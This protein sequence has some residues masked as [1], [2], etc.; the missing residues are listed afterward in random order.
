MKGAWF[1]IGA[2]LLAVAVG[3][4]ALGAHT[5]RARLDAPSLSLWETAVRYLAI[6]GVGLLAVGLAQNAT[7]RRGWTIPGACLAAGA[8]LFSG[9]I[10]AIAL[11]APR[12][13]GAITPA[14]GVLLIV[15]FL[16]TALTAVRR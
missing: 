1:P 15:G 12:W 5:L 8:V 10:G 13:L 2:I 16:A 3:G 9:T 7:P 4:G 11:G 14:G 6:G